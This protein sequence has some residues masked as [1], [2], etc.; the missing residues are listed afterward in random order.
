MLADSNCHTRIEKFIVTV[1]YRGCLHKAS[2]FLS[3]KKNSKLKWIKVQAIDNSSLWVKYSDRRLGYTKRTLKYT[4]FAII[5][6]ELEVK[7][8]SNDVL[9]TSIGVIYSPF[10]QKNSG[11]DIIYPSTLDYIRRIGNPIKET[12]NMQKYCLL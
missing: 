10:R 3:C 7:Y 1:Y 8:P 6:S 2:S 4:S 9:D 11:F 5:Y 12:Y